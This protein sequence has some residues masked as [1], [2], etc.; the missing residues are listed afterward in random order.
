MLGTKIAGMLQFSDEMLPVSKVEVVKRH[1]PIGLGKYSEVRPVD[2]VVHRVGADASA[3]VQRLVERTPTLDVETN[4]EAIERVAAEQANWRFFAMHSVNVGKI[5]HT[6]DG[7]TV[8]MDDRTQGGQILVLS[9]SNESAGREQ[10]ESMGKPISIPNFP[11][12][13]QQIGRLANRL[14]FLHRRMT[15]VNALHFCIDRDNLSC[16][17]QPG[18][19]KHFTPDPSFPADVL[20]A[21]LRLSRIAIRN[22]QHIVGMP[23]YSQSRCNTMLEKGL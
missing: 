22:I 11:G 8:Y 3:S 16:S 12:T 15:S 23:K 5:F 9:S 1:K 21:N 7:S 6:Q 4:E 20:D 19:M 2:A 13:V 18:D 17:V 14:S 10:I